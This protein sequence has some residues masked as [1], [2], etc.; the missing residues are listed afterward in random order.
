MLASA[1]CHVSM[2]RGGKGKKICRGNF[3]VKLLQINVH[4]TLKRTYSVGNNLHQLPRNP[5]DI[6]LL[7]DKLWTHYKLNKQ[8]PSF[9]VVWRKK[10]RT[11]FCLSTHVFVMLVHGHPMLLWCIFM[12]QYF[13]CQ[14]NVHYT[15]YILYQI[16][17]LYTFSVKLCILKLTNSSKL[18]EDMNS[19]N[20]R[21]WI[22]WVDIKLGCFSDTRPLYTC[23]K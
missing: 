20:T 12:G 16:G 4:H 11:A 8:I 23:T 5:W 6:S 14:S 1:F 9:A 22:S 15:T 10:W 17:T 7:N 2:C 18:I 3:S 13:F 19:S 21:S